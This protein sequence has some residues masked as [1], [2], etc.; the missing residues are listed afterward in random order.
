VLFALVLASVFGSIEVQV[1]AGLVVVVVA[2]SVT[3]LNARRRQKKEAKMK[4][5]ELMLQRLNT[6]TTL[7]EAM[8]VALVGGEKTALNPTPDPGLV[9]IVPDLL[10]RTQKIETTL[11][12]N[13]G[14]NNTIVDRMDRLEKMLNS[15]V[16]SVQRVEAAQTQVKENLAA[17][18]AN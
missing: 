16:A 10:R 1:A 18:E 6:L 7:T 11:F 9:T 14:R 4:N 2:A 13:G 17:H 5:E 15:G 12:T 8:H 3:S